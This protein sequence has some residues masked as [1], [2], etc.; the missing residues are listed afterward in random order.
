MALLGRR[1]EGE[2]GTRPLEI[3]DRILDQGEANAIYGLGDSA[4]QRLAQVPAVEPAG[5]VGF[6][7][8]RGR[9]AAPV[10]AFHQP[11]REMQ[12][13]VG[14]QAHAPGADVEEVVRIVRAVSEAAR[15]RLRR[16]EHKDARAA[17]HHPEEMHGK[18]RAGETCADDRDVEGEV[19]HRR[20]PVTPA[21]RR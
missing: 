13:V 12:H 9:P 21:V 14:K 11:A 18:R 17:R 6:R 10:T 16:A 8:F 2:A 20:A 4:A 7:N 3:G 5:H 15:R 1:A 19:A